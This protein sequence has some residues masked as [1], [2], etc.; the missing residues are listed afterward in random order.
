MLTIS[1][2]D[3]KKQ[4][5]ER[6]YRAEILEKVYHLLDLVEVFMTIP[7]LRDRLVLKGGTA[8]NLFCAEDLPRLSVDLDFNYIGSADKEV[9]KQEKIEL[10]RIILDLCHRRRYTLHRNPR[11]H[12]GGKMVL[13]YE[14][15]LGT[16][17]RLEIDLNYIFRIPLWKPEWRYSPDWPKRTQVATLDIHELAAGKLH[18]LLGREASR[19][20]FD[21][22]HLLTTWPLDN[23]K[24]RLAFT[25]YTA[26][27]RDSWKRIGLDNIACTVKEVRDQ[28]LPVLQ[29]TYAPHTSTKDLK[30]WVEK[31][32]EE[33]KNALSKVMPFDA[34]EIEFLERLADH[35]EIK[36][37]LLSDDEDFNT[38]VKN[39]PSLQ[40][41]AIQAKKTSL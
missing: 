6:G 32:I 26:M 22:Y 20:L 8:L 1:E 5:S 2:Y 39:H 38:R 25:V 35:G 19:D 29:R 34:N 16:K 3:L 18:A 13:I 37:E 30:N 41:R 36:P 17:G 15:L 31:L 14:S 33:T 4:A 28:L 12:A 9:M 27:E 11:A 40:W 24:L 10:E 21:S 7:Y 23:K